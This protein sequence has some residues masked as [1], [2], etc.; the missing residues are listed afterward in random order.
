MKFAYL[1]SLVLLLALAGKALGGLRMWYR[2][3]ESSG[4]STAT[5]SSGNNYHGTVTDANFTGAGGGYDGVGGALDFGV[6]NPQVAVP[7]SV[8][9]TISTQ[10][11][12]AFW[13]YGDPSVQPQNQDM[14]YANWPGGDDRIFSHVPWGD[15]IIFW[16]V[17]DGVGGWEVCS[18]AADKTNQYKG[19]WNHWAFTKDNGQMKMYL[20]GQLWHSDSG[21]VNVIEGITNFVIGSGL[22]GP[23]AGL[24]DEFA[25]WDYPLDSDGILDVY[26]NGITVYSGARNPNPADGSEHVDVGTV[27]SWEPPGDVC[28]PAY[29]LY[30][31]GTEPNF[32]GAS[33]A[34]EGLSEP[35]YDPDPDLDYATKYYWRVDV[36]DPNGGSPVIRQGNVW[37][38]D[39]AGTAWAPSPSDSAKG[40]SIDTDLSWTADAIAASHDVYFGTD[41]AGLVLQGNVNEPNYFD[42]P[43]LTY[44][45]IYH[46]RVDERDSNDTVLAPGDVWKFTTKWDRKAFG[47]IKV[48]VYYYPWYGPGAGGHGFGDTLR[49]H[50]LPKQGPELGHYNSAASNVISAHIDQSL[51]ANIHFWVCS[52]WGPSSYEDDV[53]KNDILTH[54]RADELEY[55]IFYETSGRLGEYGSHD[56]GNLIPDFNYI[57]ENYFDGDNYLR[58]DS[59][60]VVFMYITDLY[61]SDTAGETALANLRAAFPT[62][63]LVADDVFG[64]FYSS[65][66]AS[67]WDAVTGYDVYGQTL[68]PYGSTHAALDQLE[69]ILSDAKTAANSVGVGLIPF[70]SPGF[71]NR[72][73]GPGMS[74]A[75]RY[76]EDDPCSLEGDLFREMLR[77]VVVP[78]VD[79]LAENMLMVTSFNEWHEDTQIEPTA[80]TAGTTN[81]DDSASGDL[82]TEGDYYTDY[83]YLYLDILL[84]ETCIIGGDLNQ[85]CFVNLMDFAEI[86][87]YWLQN[88]PS[89]DIAPAGGGDGIIDFHDVAVFAENWL[90]GYQM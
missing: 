79:M 24:V 44:A 7:A 27:L 71:N 87:R 39:T 26:N 74:G 61:F 15:G 18:K 43:R 42:L 69:N 58:I 48:G 33:A 89:V 9:S 2:F 30:L 10:I 17:G 19:R 66:S 6:G 38:F 55:A 3:D 78:K 75:P 60:P 35:N 64:R 80:G 28:D 13:I 41:P 88:E 77:D 14:F 63:Y 51:Q 86:A 52:W 1:M 11:T 21:Y 57:N 23:Y 29:D 73:T 65:S 4:A 32:V 37:T 85:D 12:L 90:E 54:E 49:D 31:V 25:I 45:T 84:Q 72:G 5:D 22:D 67:K 76:F 50:L 40:I 62:A 59:R 82:Y 68:M 53:F 20:N 81:E 34:A 8:F 47:D 46:W 83:G 56:Y 16:N 36:N 70:A